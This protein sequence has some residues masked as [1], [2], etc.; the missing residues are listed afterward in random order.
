MSQYNR[1]LERVR[2]RPALE[3]LS[4][5]CLTQT[6]PCRVDGVERRTPAETPSTRMSSHRWRRGAYQTPSTRHYVA[7]RIM[8]PLSI[9]VPCLSAAW[10]GTARNTIGAFSLI[11]SGT[12]A[13]RLSSPA[14]AQ[15]FWRVFAGNK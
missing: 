8:T 5:Y 11:S 1:V 12:G 13:R 7:R 2:R 3:A 14:T 6:L 10:A 4:N 15:T 9:T